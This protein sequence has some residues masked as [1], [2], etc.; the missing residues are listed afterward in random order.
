MSPICWA[1]GYDPESFTNISSLRR[2]PNL[3]AGA[4]TRKIPGNY[5]VLVVRVSK[6]VWGTVGCT[7]SRIKSGMK[8]F[9]CF[10]GRELEVLDA[11]AD[12]NF[13]TFITC[14]LQKLPDNAL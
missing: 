13:P 1:R 10:F 4:T 12:P 11:H 6:Q 8:R 14:S 3:L 9:F 7:R 2:A 5:N